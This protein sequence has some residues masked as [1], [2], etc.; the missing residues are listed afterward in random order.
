MDGIAKK[1]PAYLALGGAGSEI[2][3]DF[4]EGFFASEQ[5]LFIN[6]DRRSLKK[7]KKKS[8]LIGEKCCKG[9]SAGR[10]LIFGKNAIDETYR[11]ILY[12]LKDHTVVFIIAGLGGG[13]GSAA[14]HLAG[15]LIRSGKRVHLILSILG[16]S[17]E[18]ERVGFLTDDALA[19]AE[20]IKPKL[21][22]FLVINKEWSRA[23]RRSTVRDIFSQFHSDIAKQ[24]SSI[25]L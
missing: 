15:K 3:S 6:T 13:T 12:R 8:L 20:I 9:L 1:K 11:K 4:D 19:D 7:I 2:L 23:D 17:G 5:Q 22:S 10:C 21:S 24:V 16:L 18:S 25:Q 14:P